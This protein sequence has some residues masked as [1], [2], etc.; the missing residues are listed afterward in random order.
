LHDYDE[1]FLKM[2]ENNAK[3]ADDYKMMKQLNKELKKEKRHYE[4]E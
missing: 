1:E 2:Q 3:I 4:N